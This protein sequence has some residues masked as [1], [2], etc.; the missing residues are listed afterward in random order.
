MKFIAVDRVAA[1]EIIS[2][3][4]YQSLEY[5]VGT[6]L[7]QLLERPVL[8]VR[9]TPRITPHRDADGLFILSACHRPR[10]FVIFDEACGLF[11]GRHSIESSLL[12]LHKVL[13]F[14]VKL[15]DNQR[16][17]PSETL[18]P[19]STIAIVFPNPI[20]QRTNFR[21]SIDTSPDSER[22][23]KREHDGR[24]LLVYRSGLDDGGGPNQPVSI[25]NFRRFL[26]GRRALPPIHST[27]ELAYPSPEVTA[28]SVTALQGPLPTRIQPYQQYDAWM[29]FL[30]SK[31]K[32]FVT[33]DFTAP[34]RIEGPAGT[35]KTMCLI[36]K[37]IYCLIQAQ[38]TGE[39]HSAL[40]IAHSES[41]KRTIRQLIDYIDPSQFLA[42]RQEL[43]L[44]SLKLATLQELCGEILDQVIYENE[45]L[46]RDA[47]DSKLAQLAYVHDSLRGAM[48]EDYP[49][50]KKFLSPE[51]DSFL[52]TTDL[53]TVAEML[54]H[55]IAVIIKGRADEN[56]ERY[57]RL[58]KLRYGLP[59]E[60][61]SDRGFVFVIFGRYRR[62]LERSAQF[63]TDDIVITAFK[64]LDTPIWR[65]RRARE[66]YD[67]IY[68]DETHLFNINELTLFHHLTR[69][70]D[71]YPIAYSV[72]RS[73]ALGDRGWNDQ[74]FEETLSPDPESRQLAARTEIKS[75]F[76]CS[77]YIIDLAFSVTSSGA[78]LFTNFED[79]LKLAVSMFTPEEVRKCTVPRLRS[80]PNDAEMIVKAFTC[81]DSLVKELD[82]ARSNVVIVAFTDELFRQIQDYAR[83][84]NKPVELLKERGDIEAVRRAQQSG[85]FVLSTPDYIGGLEFDGAVLVGVDEGRVP[86]S[87]EV[88]SVDSANYL[89]YASHNRLY[90]AVTRARYRVEILITDE[91]GPSR[92][93]RAGIAAHFIEPTL[94]SAHA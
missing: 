7:A 87:R 35:G 9:L 26:S 17:S 24:S 44:Q 47:M 45:F 27:A 65:R 93:L 34:H 5:E 55:E 21:I 3:R 30:T 18:I 67:S 41:T 22:Q 88:E 40:F 58:P 19:G 78:T 60:T 33:A 6:A 80:Y 71:R 69:Q 72:D 38:R 76:R 52:S 61:E 53:W 89:C 64:Q 84:H 94:D 32:H 10:D 62:Q 36:L 81:A 46:D 37:S 49:T 70:M 57:R 51:F 42:A 82:V 79:P 54:Q 28:L 85:R 25:T 29:E 91:R 23:A 59:V 90:V 16:L 83:A 2:D 15:W 11:E 31:Q 73:Q 66:G 74:L 39:E 4:R 68:I 8:D 13:R 14:A 48:E 12:Y 56:L 43:R 75:I 86:P 63:D 20:S 1:T 50:H 77:P 92:L